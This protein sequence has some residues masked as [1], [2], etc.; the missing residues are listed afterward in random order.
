M[1]NLNSILLEGNLK[2]DPVAK[3]NEETK[4]FCTEFFVVS[5]RFY[6]DKDGKVAEKDITAKVQTFGELAE[7]MSKDAKKERGI[8]VV[9][10]IDNDEKG[11]VFIVAE[12]C[13][14]RPEIKKAS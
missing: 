10:R 2:A 1:N 6:K 12:H 8:R 13:E 4:T 9:G 5:K 14:L 3:N 7:R 11:Q